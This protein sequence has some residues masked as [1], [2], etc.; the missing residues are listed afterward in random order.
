M[1]AFQTLEEI[2]QPSQRE[3][4]LIRGSQRAAVLG[5]AL[6]AGVISDFIWYQVGRIRGGKVLTLL[7]RISLEP[8]SCV[9]RTET[10]FAKH[11]A[12]SLLIAKF[13]PVRTLV[14]GLVATALG[15]A[16]RGA[17][18]GILVLYA[19]TA[20]TGFGVAIMHPSMPPLVRAWLPHRI[21]F[22]SAVFTNGLIVGEVIPVALTLPLVVPLVGGW[23]ASFAACANV[24]MT[25]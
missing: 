1:D 23:R 17:A 4:A 22:G 25:G 14:L 11:G 7:C 12:K 18:P 15:S 10:T 8:D 24:L 21:G 19:A 3:L 2:D 9:R 6:L 16:L 20:L 13:G 5:L